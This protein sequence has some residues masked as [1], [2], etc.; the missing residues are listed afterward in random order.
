MRP[1][2]PSIDLVSLQSIWRN[3]YFFTKLRETDGRNVHGWNRTLDNTRSVAK[4]LVVCQPSRS[5]LAQ[6]QSTSLVHKRLLAHKVRVRNRDRLGRD[7]QKYEKCFATVG[8]QRANV[9]RLCRCTTHLHIGIETGGPACSCRYVAASNG[10]IHL[11]LIVNIQPQGLA[12]LVNRINESNVTIAVDGSLYRFHPN[13][14]NNMENTMKLVVHP[15]IKVFNMAWH[16]HALQNE[17]DCT[18]PWSQHSHLH[19]TTK[20]DV[21]VLSDL[22]VLLNWWKPITRRFRIYS[23]NI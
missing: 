16:W 23:Y 11:I 6:W 3:V 17:F 14:K 12:V 22:F 10:L 15:H 20:S 5:D 7:I 9:R 1:P 18:T 8:L 21:P 4:E 19:S 2:P 13:F